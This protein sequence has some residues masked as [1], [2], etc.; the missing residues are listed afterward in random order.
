[1]PKGIGRFWWLPIPLAKSRQFDRLTMNVVGWVIHKQTPAD[2]SEMTAHRQSDGVW[3]HLA[4]DEQTI[5]W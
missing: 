2:G 3:F 1:M 5:R 4:W